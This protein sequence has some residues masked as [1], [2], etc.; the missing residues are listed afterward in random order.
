MSK[1]PTPLP[2]G[3]ENPSQLKEWLEKNPKQ[4]TGRTPGPR[5]IGESSK[6]R[7]VLAHSMPD[8]DGP[9]HDLVDLDDKQRRETFHCD[10]PKCSAPI[11]AMSDINLREPTS[12]VNPG[13][14]IECDHCGCGF[15][16]VAVNPDT[17]NPGHKL[18]L[19]FFAGPMLMQV[20]NRK[21]EE[22]A[23]RAARAAR[24]ATKH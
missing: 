8:P 20:L 9:C 13:D 1:P 17:I 5:K 23:A 7:P 15:K 21:R 11:V 12:Y 2:I 24:Q 22:K 18:Q 6:G 4:P 19:E 3:V 14:M 16:V 10:C